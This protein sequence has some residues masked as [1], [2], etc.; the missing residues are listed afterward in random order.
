[1]GF[2]MMEEV[3]A[4]QWLAK[5][6]VSLTGTELTIAGVSQEEIGQDKDRKFALHFKFGAKPLILNKTNTR[7]LAVLFGPNS[8]NWMGK[9]IVAYNDPTVGYAGQMTGGVRLRVATPAAPAF[10]SQ[11]TPAQLKEVA[12]AYARAQSGTPAD[13][14][15]DLESDV[16]F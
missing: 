3:L 8:D 15:A 5:E 13:P 1:M 7:I 6:D 11:L 9:Q 12:A 14:M 4:S 10:V 2:N 16:P